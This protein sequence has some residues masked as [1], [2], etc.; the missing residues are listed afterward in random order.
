MG[1]KSHKILVICDYFTKAINA[2]DMTSFTSSSFIS[3]FKDFLQFTGPVT[4]LL[5]VDNATFFGNKEVLTFLHTIGITK[6]RGN[7]N[8]SESR[9]L[10]ESSIRIL[11]TLIRK[12]LALSP[13]YDFKSILF[14]APV[15]L[16]RAPNPITGYLPYEMLFGKDLSILGSLGSNIGTPKYKLFTESVKKEVEEF[17]KLM[18]DR[19]SIV[20]KR[21]A[22]EKEKYLSKSNSGKKVKPAYPLGSTVFLKDFSVPKSGRA[23]KFQPRFLKSPNVVVSSSA[24][25]VVTMRLADGYISRHHPDDM[26]PYRGSEKTSSL[27]QDLPES[28]LRFLGRPLSS[29]ALVDLAVVL[30]FIFL[31]AVFDRQMPARNAVRREVG[32]RHGP[33]AGAKARQKNISFTRP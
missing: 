15:L 14:L 28:V 33:F 10:V 1:K 13:K 18:E 9:G 12:L 32:P 8:H 20:S 29:E 22:E 30:F 6:V 21:I 2:F 4:K 23:S 11:Q 17:G 24:T 7:A 3:R 31:W 19:I 5:V 26:L 25:S 16:N 27:H